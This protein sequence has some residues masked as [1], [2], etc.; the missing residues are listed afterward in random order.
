MLFTLEVTE[1]GLGVYDSEGKSVMLLDPAEM[2]HKCEQMRLAYRKTGKK[3]RN[4]I[5]QIVP[6]DLLRA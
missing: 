4:H 6:R 1:H 2:V 3:Q 5:Y